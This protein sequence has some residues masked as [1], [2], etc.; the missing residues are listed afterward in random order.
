MDFPFLL[1]S[2]AIKQRGTIKRFGYQGNNLF[3][4][5]INKNILPLSN[6]VA[7]TVLETVG[8][9]LDTTISANFKSRMGT[10]R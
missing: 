7:E 4:Y 3:T 1:I 5:V 10:P 9:Q 6:D 2:R 8:K